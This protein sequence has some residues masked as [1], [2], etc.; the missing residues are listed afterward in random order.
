MVNAKIEAAKMARRDVTDEAVWKEHISAEIDDKF[1]SCFALMQDDPL[2]RQEL[3]GTATTLIALKERITGEEAT[4]MRELLG[5]QA[6]P[7]ESQSEEI[8]KAEAEAKP[9]EEG[10]PDIERELFGKLKEEFT[11]L[12]E[13]ELD[14][15]LH[16]TIM[17]NEPKEL[18]P[19]TMKATYET[20]EVKTSSAPKEGEPL[21]EAD[22]KALDE[23]MKELDSFINE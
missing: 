8:K 9:V 12:H 11:S 16:E 4:N 19:V 10:P 17:Q 13:E 15:L 23:I 7:S 5:L 2:A 3:L 18:P 20:V 6:L 21:S 22:E 14:K 1:G